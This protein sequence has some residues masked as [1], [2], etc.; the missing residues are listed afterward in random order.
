MILAAGTYLYR[1]NALDKIDIRTLNDK[2]LAISPIRSLELK[3][4]LKYILEHY[5]FFCGHI[6]LIA[7]QLL[8]REP[9]FAPIVKRKIFSLSVCITSIM[10][11]VRSIHLTVK[12]NLINFYIFKI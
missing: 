6:L 10:K 7:R 11:V 3:Q 4:V 8:Y 9:W 2:K 1:E 12:I 5:T